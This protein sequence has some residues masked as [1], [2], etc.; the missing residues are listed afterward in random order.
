MEVGNISRNRQTGQSLSRISVADI[1]RDAAD[2]LHALCPS[3]IH[4]EA[5]AHSVDCDSIDQIGM[6]PFLASADIAREK[7]KGGPQLKFKVWLIAM[8]VASVTY[9]Y[10]KF[11]Y[12][13][14][15]KP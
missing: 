7:A 15:K 14:R 2:D 1:R 4:N 12:G 11:K 9:I 8:A 6:P 5:A 3:G 13:T 10:F